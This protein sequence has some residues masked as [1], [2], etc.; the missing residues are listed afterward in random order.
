[1]GVVVAYGLILP[2]PM[3]EAPRAGLPQ[4]ARLRP[5]A[6]A[7][8]RPDPA[9]D[10]GRRHGDRR[11]RH[12]HG[13]G[14]RHRARL[15]RGAA[16]RSGPTPR[17]ASCTTRW[18]RA[19]RPDGERAGGA[20]GLRPR[21]PG[22]GRG[23]RH[24]RTQDRQG[25]DAHRFLAA[26][27][28]GAQPHPRP[29]RR[30][31]A[32]GSRPLAAPGPSASRCCAARWRRARGRPERCSTPRRPSPAGRVPSACW[33]CSARAKRPAAAEDFL[34]GFHMPP[35]TAARRPRVKHRRNSRGED[36]AGDTRIAASNNR[37]E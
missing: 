23:R 27:A 32:P 28:R 20:G 13:R 10:H 21:M 31:R 19:A 36:R 24:L 9:R 8:R 2:K 18:R 11:D 7:R 1:M 30:R 25:R 35:G 16:C 6:L 17:R 34:R 33:R 15:P 14:A 3:L 29:R 12:A 22:T 5:A 37:V 4:P 26:R